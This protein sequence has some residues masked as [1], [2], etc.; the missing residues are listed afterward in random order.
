MR[1]QYASVFPSLKE[2]YVGLLTGDVNKRC[3]STKVSFEISKEIAVAA[4]EIE[5]I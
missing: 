1:N 3:N 4:T 2:L 5:F